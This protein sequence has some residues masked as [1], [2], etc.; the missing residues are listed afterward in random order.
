VNNLQ[1]RRNYIGI[2]I[3]RVKDKL[4][5]TLIKKLL[6]FEVKEIWKIISGR[7]NLLLILTNSWVKNM[8]I[9]RF[10]NSQRRFK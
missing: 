8:K 3:F 2:I 7:F 10:K 9:E 1:I 5:F 4:F 6:N